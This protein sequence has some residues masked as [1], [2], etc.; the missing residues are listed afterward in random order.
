MLIW[1]I[2]LLA[3][4]TMVSIFALKMKSLKVIFG[5]LFAI[6]MLAS[7]VMLAAN[8]NGH[9]GMEKTT[10][11]S[12]K[13][14]YSILPAQSPVGAVA[15]KKI[16]S[17]NYVLVYKDAESD[18]QASTHFVPNTKKVV[19]AVKQ[20]ATYQKGNVTTAE[21]KTKTVKWTYKSDFYKFLFK[22]K[23]EDNIVSVRHTLIVPENWQ[24]VEK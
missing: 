1:I 3:V 20:K 21:V 17:D 4:L 12:T 11:T 15:V 14:V 2:A 9:Y 7:S 22:Q 23:D 16:G 13:Q 18:V 5:G 19:E 24:V 10:T 8:M 6:L